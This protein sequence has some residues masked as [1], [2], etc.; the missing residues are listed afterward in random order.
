MKRLKIFIGFMVASCFMVNA[1]FADSYPTRGLAAQSIKISDEL[2]KFVKTNPPNQDDCG[3]NI[4]FAASY[5]ISASHELMDNNLS[6][7]MKDFLSAENE[8][9]KIEFNSR[10]KE[11]FQKIRPFISIIIDLEERLYSLII[12]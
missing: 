3:N 8:L 9:K 4:V 1:V 12:H 6:L 11:N 7:A 10:C 2:L 5:L